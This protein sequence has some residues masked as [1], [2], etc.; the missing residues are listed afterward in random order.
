MKSRRYDP[1]RYS[2]C[3]IG[4]SPAS[5]D[6]RRGCAYWDLDIDFCIYTKMKEEER[7]RRKEEGF[8]GANLMERMRINKA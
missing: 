6:I 7:R 3:P 5:C 2:R 4:R 8:D 1:D